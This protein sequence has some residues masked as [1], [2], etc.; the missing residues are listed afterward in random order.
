MG[1][2]GEV[3]GASPCCVFRLEGLMFVEGSP[4]RLLRGGEA[5]SKMGEGS[6]P[7]MCGMSRERAGGVLRR[8]CVGPV[9]G[10]GPAW[11]R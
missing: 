11:G 1:L 3:V 8:L 4:P 5:K 6:A 10:A 2:K 9:R 7:A